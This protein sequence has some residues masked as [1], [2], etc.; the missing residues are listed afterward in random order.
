MNLLAEEQHFFVAY[1]AQNSSANQSRCWNWFQ[2][3]DQQRDQGE[4]SL[5][6][7]ITQQIMRTHHVDPQRVYVAGLSSGGAMAMIMGVTY[8]E[9]FAAIGVHSGLAYGAAHDL[10]S[11][12]AAMQQGRGAPALTRSHLGRTDRRCTLVIPT[13]VFHGD[14]DTTVHH[15]NG[16]Q[17]LAQWAA[18]SVNESDSRNGAKLRVTVSQGHVPAGHAYTHSTYHDATGQPVMEQ[19]LIHGA[20]HAWSGGSHTGSF[21][22]PN[23]PDATQ[24]M[25]R[26]F[27]AHPQA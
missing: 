15:R 22:D 1:P 19:W 6:A 27:F 20:G 4:P 16:E 12:F 5:I 7:G 23:G 18:L 24:E 13:I 8:P 25:V 9:I 17:V 3:G 2:T 26:F 14:R 11:A 21:T 10:P